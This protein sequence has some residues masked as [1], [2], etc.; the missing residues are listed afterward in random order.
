MVN[1]YQ[2][3]IK[4]Y[5]ARAAPLTDLLKK[6]RA[7]EWDKKCQQAFDDLKNVVTKESVLALPDHTKAFE[8][9]TDASDFAI[10]GVLMQDR[11]LIAFKSR[12][13]NDT[14]RRYTI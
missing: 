8:I 6:N 1:Y 9:H 4:G 12:K 2:W 5:S 14:K 7:W 13:L 3:F 11:H 10:M